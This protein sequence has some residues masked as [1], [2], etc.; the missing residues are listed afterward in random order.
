M[1]IGDAG[2]GGDALLKLVCH[3]QI[4]AAV[5]ADDPHIDLRRQTEIQD[6]RDDVGRLEI[7]HDIGKRGRQHLAQLAHVIGGRRVALLQRHHDHP[8]IGADGRAVGEGEIIGACRQ[9]D[10]VDDQRAVGIR[11]HLADLVLDRL[12]DTLGALDARPGGCAHMQ[13]NLAAVDQ[14]IEVA[15]D[16]D[17]HHRAKR[18]HENGDGR[19][20]QL[21][22]Q[23]HS[24]Q[25]CITLAH[26]FE[27]AFE[28]AVEAGERP[29]RRIVGAMMLAL[30]QQPDGDRSER[31][32]QRVRGK[33]REHDR[34]GR[35]A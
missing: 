10:I 11:D 14:R 1:R 34:Q 9:P 2:N 31:A 35:A 4:V 24:E 26:R 30:Q 3:F 12:E 16:K 33:H 29:A 22:R 8:V 28:G 6:L 5:G 15:A 13:L 7:E 19:H 17:E 18:Q 32:R 25:A 23:Q 27:A 20:D 21:P